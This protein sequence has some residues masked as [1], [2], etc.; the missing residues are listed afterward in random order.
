M[1]NSDQFHDHPQ[2]FRTL[3]V[4]SLMLLLGLRPL[5]ANTELPLIAQGIQIGDVTQGRAIIWS[6]ADRPARMMVEYAFNPEF[7]HAKLLAGPYAL[8]NTDFTARLDL[9]ELPPGHDVYLKV[10]FKDLRSPQQERQAVNGHF[11]TLG[12]NEDIHFVWGGD[13]AGQGW[14]INES[15]GG[16]KIY[17][18]MR[19]LEP[20]FFIQSGDNV[21]ADAIIPNHKTAENGQDWTNLVVYGVNKAAE[22]LD[23]FRGRYKYNLSDSNLRSFNAEVPQIWQWDDHEVVNNWSDAKDLSKDDR[24]QVKDVPLLVA[25]A[26]TAFH[27]YAPLRPNDTTESSRIYRKLSLN[28]LLDVF[29]LD[30]RSYRGPNSDNLQTQAGPDTAFLGETQLA[31]LKHELQHSTAVWKVISA[32]MPLGLNISDGMDAAGR[33]RWEAIA[34]GDNGPPAGRELEF[35]ALLQFIKRHKINN[36]VWLSAETHSPAVHYYDP[37]QAAFTGFNG[38]WEFVAGPLNAGA[39]CAQ[40]PDATFGLQ[41]KFN[42]PPLAGPACINPK[43]GFSPYAGLQFFGEVNIS[44]K[45]RAMTVDLKDLNGDKIMPSIILPAQSRSH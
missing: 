9:T 1:R 41:V 27:E 39:F 44:H 29:V 16:M 43:D 6:R 32:D 30:M 36:I 34:N 3:T 4:L 33:P 15:F 20:Q 24:Y 2:K 42:A 45:T 22:T 8:E 40:K 35:A 5:A 23:E 7:N 12:V 13:T 37:R 26:T 17:T 11:R 21:Y 10:W 18:T 25:R 14:G 19:R 38:F 28:K 31:W